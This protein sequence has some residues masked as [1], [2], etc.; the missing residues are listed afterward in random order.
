LLAIQTFVVVRERNS[1]SRFQLAGSESVS[2]TAALLGHL[3]RAYLLAHGELNDETD[4]QYRLDWTKTGLVFAGLIASVLYPRRPQLFHG[5]LP[6]DN[7]FSS[8]AWSRNTWAWTLPLLALARTRKLEHSDLPFLHHEARSATL[9][10]NFYEQKASRTLFWKLTYSVSPGLIRQ[11]VYTFLDSF[12]N[13]APQLALFQLLR[14]F[15]ERDEGIP[16]GTR[17]IVWVAA[18]G[19][20]QLAEGYIFA[21][22][23]WY[24]EACVYV[25]LR[26]QIG[27]LVFAKSMRKKDV[28]GTTKKTD[29]DDTNKKVK[30]DPDAPPKAADLEAVP[31]KE[32]DE[33]ELMR[34]S[35]QGVVNLIGTDAQRIGMLGLFNNLLSG[36][37]IKL[38][39]AL[40]FLQALVGWQAMLVGIAVNLSFLPLNIYFS[41]R[42]TALQDVL[43]QARDKKLAVVNEALTGIRQIKFAALEK[44]WEKKILDVR[45]HEL[46]TLWSVVKA[47]IVLIFIWLTGP[48]F[49]STACIATHALIAGRLEPSVAF[50]TV[51]ILSK[52][53]GTLSY[54]PELITHFA[55]ALVSIKRIDEY[56]HAPERQIVAQPGKKIAFE[57][58]TISWPTDEVNEDAFKLH[59]ISTEFPIGELSV[60]SGKTGSGK[61][62]MLSAILGECELH[63][64]TITIPEPPS[65]DERNDKN[66]NK[67]NWILQNCVAYVPQIPWIENA[68][69]RDN[70]VFGLPFDEE[71]YKQVIHACSLEKDLEILVDGDKTEIGPRGINLSGGQ[72][73]R[74]TLA[75]ALYSRAGLLIM[76]DIFSA[77]DAHVGRHI[78]EN[79][80]TGPISEGR[81]RIL[82]THHVA[83]C[84]PKTKYEVHLGDGT[85]DHAGLVDDLERSGVLRTVLE[86][87]SAVIDD[88]EALE[89]TMESDVVQRRL[90]SASRRLSRSSALKKSHTRDPIPENTQTTNGSAETSK[91]EVKKFVEDEETETG[92]VTMRIYWL[93]M[94]GCGGAWFW[95]GVVILFAVYEFL[96]LSRVSHYIFL[97]RLKMVLTR[98]AIDLGSSAMD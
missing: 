7:Q 44:Q 77:V 15:E 18:F 3:L 75:R 58:A 29:E 86:D 97:R 23:W 94:K 42:Y 48:M 84:L 33:S 61:S 53:E 6:V 88:S 96:L 68:T 45:E 37:V 35:R 65:I 40:Y 98:I 20:L 78:F 25:P 66:A 2:F 26:V 32:E 73:W 57:K 19:L 46:E 9:V 10:K 55:D 34:K 72:C 70:I 8:S 38:S 28:K 50:T 43:M 12:F 89:T 51:S 59:N 85:V 67:G 11:Q 49:L 21:R 93:Y 81:T 54:I 17:G 4:L 79:A 14:L 91:K 22:S 39:V 27:A 82:V 24:G 83:L 95:V 92:R 90:S 5:D 80:L 62:L 41:K 60:I 47:D 56:L 30:D 1:V 63:S 74:L 52:I 31:E 64:G 87:E 36:S 76:D 69:F 13:F 71:R 16:I